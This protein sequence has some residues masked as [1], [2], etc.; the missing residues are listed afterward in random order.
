MKRNVP[1]LPGKPLQRKTPLKSAAFNRLAAREHKTVSKLKSRGMKGRTPTVEEQRFMD[2]IAGLG[3]IACAKDGRVNPW[4]SIHHIKG[5]TAPGAHM[6]VLGLCS[7]HHQH[8]DADPLGRIGVHPYKARFEQRYGTQEQLL[9][10][11]MAKIG[12][13]ATC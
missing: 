6:L 5:R 7:E 9:A 11:C 1:L 8:D 12:W 10:E 13:S 3:C 4:I 2:A